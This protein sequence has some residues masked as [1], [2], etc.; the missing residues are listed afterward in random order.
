MMMTIFVFYF[1]LYPIP[2]TIITLPI[3]MLLNILPNKLS[4]E[5]SPVISIKKTLTFLI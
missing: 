1:T 4:A 2:Y 5:T 3:Q